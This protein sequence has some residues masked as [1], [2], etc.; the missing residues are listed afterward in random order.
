M[1]YLPVQP[2]NNGDVKIQQSQFLPAYLDVWTANLWGQYVHQTQAVPTDYFQ[3]IITHFVTFWNWLTSQVCL[4]ENRQSSKL[5]T[6]FLLLLQIPHIAA[7]M[8]AY[9]CGRAVTVLS[10]LAAIELFC[11]QRRSETEIGNKFLTERGL[12]CSDAQV[13][14]SSFYVSFCIR[15]TQLV[16]N[17]RSLFEFGLVLQWQL[18]TSSFSN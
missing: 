14:P 3:F 8:A 11:F 1:S 15:M 16:V 5:F 13:L 9:V 2:F 17:S 4:S 6:F 12:I 7:F 10:V 18:F